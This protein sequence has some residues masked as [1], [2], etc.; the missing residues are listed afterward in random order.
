LAFKMADRQKMAHSK[1]IAVARSVRADPRTVK[2]VAEGKPVRG[3]VGID[4]EE[5]FKRRGW[6]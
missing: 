5:E 3:L 6:R 2:K 1:I 4:I